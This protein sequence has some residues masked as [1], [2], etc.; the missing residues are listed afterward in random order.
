MNTNLTVTHILVLGAALVLMAGVGVAQAEDTADQ[1]PD[2]EAIQ[3]AE[4]DL[5]FGWFAPDHPL[6]G[7]ETAVDRAGMSLGVTEPG[8]VAEKRANEAREMA[9]AGKWDAAQ[10]AANELE[11]AAAQSGDDDVERLET[12]MATIDDVIADA[13]DEALEGL[14]TAMANVQQA[15][16]D[17]LPEHVPDEPGDQIPDDPGEQDT[18]E[19]GPDDDPTE[20][21]P[22]VPDDG[23]DDLDGTQPVPTPAPDDRAEEDIVT[24]VMEDNSFGQDEIHADPGQPIDIVNEDGVDHTVTIDEAGIDEVLESGDEF[25]LVLDEEGEYELDCTFHPGMDA[26]IIIEE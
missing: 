18:D 4:H 13:P 8:A 9:D 10:R 26:T 15:G 25:S 2:P 20:D 19:P 17:D 1:D 7:L 24:V 23:A 21:E 12:A 5:D 22:H 11:T 14:E 3:E 16:P 6:Y